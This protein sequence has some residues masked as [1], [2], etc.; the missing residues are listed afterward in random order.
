MSRQTPRYVE[1]RRGTVG[2]QTHR[3]TQ[4]LQNPYLE[5]VPVHN[6]R[7]EI[8]KYKE[9]ERPLPEG[10]SSNDKKILQTVRRKAYKWDMSFR[11]CCFTSRFGWSFFIG[12][13]PL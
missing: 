2:T 4:W 6:N 3:L 1:F 5:K 7:G 13:V 12:L 11:F 9:R 8:V 10:L